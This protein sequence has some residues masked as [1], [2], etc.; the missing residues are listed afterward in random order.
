[1]TNPL[2]PHSS[3]LVRGIA[4][5]VL[6]GATAGAQTLALDN[7]LL[8][9]ATLADTTVTM[10]GHSELHL[11]GSGDPL[12]G[13][14]VHLNSTDSWIFLHA[15]PP[16]ATAA[17]LSHVQVNGTPA[18]LGSNVRVVQ[19]ARGAVVIPH[20]TTFRPLE[21]FSS[22]ECV[23]RSMLLGPYTAY[24]GT[25]LGSFNGAIR[26]FILK[27]GYT[28]TFAQNEN[29]S[30]SSR[31]YVAQD[32]DLVVATMPSGLDSA[33]RFVRV[34][35]WRWT[36]KKG[37]CDV[38]PTALNA[39][40]HYNWNISSNS[41]P[42]WEYAAI[43]QTRWWPGLDQDWK[44]RGINHLLGYN[45]PNNP[46]EDA[47]TS[48]DNGS[49]DTAIATW[50]DLLATGLRVG[51]PAVTDGGYNWIVDFINK[52]DAA[53]V[54]VDYVPVHYY[55]S[56]WS[57]S[58]P[59]GA[60][61]Q[62]YNYLKSIH[63]VAQR[64][65]W[66]TEFNNGA[67]WTSGPDP[68]V[69]QN[70]DTIQA[71]I[72]MMDNTPWIERYAIYS[73]V[74]WF[75]QT[76]YDDGWPTPM[77]ILYRDH[78][79]PI[80]HVQVVPDSGKSPAADY[81]FE[82]NTRDTSGS[83]NN[84]L[85]YGTPKI[86]AG[87]RGAA[88]SL[89]GADDYL[90]L[91]PRIG[92][93]TDFSFSGWVRWNGGGN[94][95]RVFDLG[96]GTARNLFLC[97]RSGDGTLRFAIKN[98]GGEQQLNGTPL[99]V[100]AWT[101]VAVTIAG[102]TGKLFVNGALVATN[103][104]M[105]INPVDVGTTTNYLGKSQWPDP[106]FNGLIDE[107]RFFAYALGDAEVAAMAGGA[108]LQFAADTLTLPTAVP[109]LPYPGSLA[110]SCTPGGGGRVF[111]KLSGPSWLVVAPDGS[112]TGLPLA[113]DAGTGTFAVRVT[114]S[115]GNVDTATLTIPVAVTGL[116]A[117]YPFDDDGSSAVGGAHATLSGSPAFSTG[118]RN[119]CINLDG[120][121]DFATLPAGVTG[122]A[123]MTVATWVNWDGGGNWQ[124][125]FDFGN[126]TGQH[127]FLCPGSSANRTLFL[128]R[129]HGVEH[130]IDTAKLPTG[131][132]IHVAATIGGGTMRLFF[133]GALVASGTTTLTPADLQATYSYIGDSQFAADPCFD[134]RL[135]EFL[136]FNRALTQA[137]IV[138]V[139]NGTAPRFTA[140][141]IA[142][143][144]TTVGAIYEQSI[145]GTATDANAGDALTYRKAGGPNWLT[146]GAHGRLSG[147]PSA[148]DSGM[149]RFLVRVT[150]AAGLADEAELRIN[151][152]GASG[153]LAH[154]Q[155][156]D[157][158]N[159]SQGGA[160]GT[161][162]GGP[163]YAD[164]YYD[165]AIRL[166]G[167]DDHV[168]L[169]ATSVTGLTDVTVA[170][171]VRWNGGANWQRI[172]DFGNNTTQY[173]FLTPKSGGNTLR[174]G[175][176]LN[177]PGA[178]QILE[179][180]VLATGEWAHVAVTLNGTTG[181]L[182]LNGTAVDS[183]DITIDPANFNPTLNYIGESQFAADP[184][185]NGLVDDFRI[186]SRSLSAAEVKD[187]AIPAAAI[188]VPDPSYEA[189][190]AGFAFATGQDGPAADPDRDQLANLLEWLSGTD[191][192]APS[193][194]ALPVARRLTA[195][196]AG[197]TGT[198]TYLG[199]AARLRMNR[200]GVALVPE[201]A[202]TL[203]ALGTPASAA[204]VSLA[205]SPV[206]DGDFETITWYHEVAIEDNPAGKAFIR[207]K[208]LKD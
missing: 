67:N 178:Q 41:T 158:P 133:N 54:R 14:T 2:R 123:E 31:N 27:R 77:G 200:P 161:S 124:R 136:V 107:A 58:D 21:V 132:W 89:D 37:S 32:S 109:G 1:M 142:R 80:G 118:L 81:L 93:S 99:T 65:I 5:L 115:A 193:D 44:W 127:L 13:S 167:A 39:D 110:T 205:G 199:L 6:L 181:T 85:V 76:H 53:G 95:Q 19:H 186:Y 117:R 8:R 145:A 164:G 135:D 12:P 48:L 162:I 130:S 50:P 47:Y 63:D 208:V 29:G 74:E 25:S 45:E 188:V 148:A 183:G 177:G 30:G 83:G 125:I 4:A 3:A 64:P 70:R 185:F 159:D 157:N 16:S 71:M 66:V 207:L 24:N 150:D 9:S 154:Y 97:P 52:A 56:Y 100:G 101:H 73:K 111:A 122:S 61:T 184:S 176:T 198:K 138:A 143:P 165:R 69:E 113:G 33:I 114:D 201:A 196:Q 128:I 49:V 96:D 78:V 36:G 46:V 189:W 92:D 88:V 187:L 151:V 72:E 131:T 17:L 68:S 134:G 204:A 57:A 60:T 106:L 192:L 15:V 94:W 34:F 153:L 55:R 103:T 59:A 7:E 174:F 120:S 137:E 108:V 202:T 11:T 87:A 104:A 149:N 116:V 146:V 182:Y 126:G 10:T 170:A 42:D 121:D 180:P 169:R 171:R 20:A 26:S 129:S 18:V 86:V 141:P 203:E 175:I 191:P 173:L 119:Q 51:A 179:A 40:W 105:T 62:L 35:P 160:S 197:L 152:S 147:I 155:F 79:A 43:R 102:D 168:R 23:G 144:A 172:F 156:N 98:G 194:L 90:R 190:A 112:L 166:D 139:R 195:A 22:P 91:P 28:A 75:R 206:A 84:P 163:A 140:V 82:G 38:A